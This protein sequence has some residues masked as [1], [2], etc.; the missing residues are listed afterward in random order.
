MGAGPNI[1]GLYSFFDAGAVPPAVPKHSFDVMVLT[2]GVGGPV[3]RVQ[4]PSSFHVLL[5]NHGV[6]GLDYF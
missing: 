3:Y 6:L 5:Q 2:S 1:Q 4:L